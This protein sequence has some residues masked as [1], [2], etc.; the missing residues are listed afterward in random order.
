MWPRLVSDD[1]PKDVSTD[2]RRD[3]S[4]NPTHTRLTLVVAAAALLSDTAADYT[5]SEPDRSYRAAVAEVRQT[6]AAVGRF[7]HTRTYHTSTRSNALSLWPGPH[8]TGWLSYSEHC[9]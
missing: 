1:M 3:K 2:L 6:I 5:K 9:T 8:R 4:D 7:V